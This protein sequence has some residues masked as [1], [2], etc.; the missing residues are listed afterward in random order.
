MVRFQGK[1]KRDSEEA[2]QYQEVRDIVQEL[3][4]VGHLFFVFSRVQV[5][6]RG[7]TPRFPEEKSS[8]PK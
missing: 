2:E 6:S 4:Q 5:F 3:S 7:T 1:G 8:D